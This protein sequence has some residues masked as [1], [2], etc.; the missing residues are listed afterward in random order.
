[1]SD[2]S[3]GLVSVVRRAMS[4]ASGPA[5]RAPESPALENGP[6]SLSKA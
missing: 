4:P 1:M 6:E 2:E 3:V 5:I